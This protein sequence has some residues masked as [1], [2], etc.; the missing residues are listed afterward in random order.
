MPNNNNNNNSN[1]TCPKCSR[2]KSATSDLCV[3]CLGK[4][5]V[6]A[7]DNIERERERDK[8]HWGQSIPVLKV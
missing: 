1:L 8:S 5:A 7:I 3:I 2:P 4:R 6:D